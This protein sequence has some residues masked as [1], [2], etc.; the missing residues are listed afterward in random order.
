VLLAQLL[1]SDDCHSSFPRSL[2]YLLKHFPLQ[3]GG[4]EE[5][6]SLHSRLGERLPSPRVR[7]KCPIIHSER[8]KQAR[9]E[10]G[11]VGKVFPGPATFGGPLSLKS[12]ENGVPD[13]F[14]LT[15]N[16]HKIHFRPPEPRWGSLR[17]SP[18]PLVR[19]RGD[20]PSHV[21]SL[22]TPLT[23]RSRRIRNEVAIGPRH[24]GPRAPLW[25]SAGLGTSAPL[26]GVRGK[27]FFTQPA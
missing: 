12:T 19:W 24:N 10:G 22:S 2:H 13:G 11:K 26:F 16:M 9:R 27:C 4:G 23:S 3:R 21:S 20:T 5:K 8:D 6:V 14:F 25:L 1:T 17:H 18:I 7:V 15:S